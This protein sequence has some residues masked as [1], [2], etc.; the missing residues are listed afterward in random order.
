VKV[1]T[2]GCGSHSVALH[3]AL[4]RCFLFFDFPLKNQAKKG[5]KG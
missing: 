3:P 4:W 1:L 2:T 5:C